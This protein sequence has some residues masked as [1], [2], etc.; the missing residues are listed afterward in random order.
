M[1]STTT[2]ITTI[3]R[4]ASKVDKHAATARVAHDVKQGMH[5][6]K[7][8]VHHGMH[9]GMHYD[10]HG[11]SSGIGNWLH[12]VDHTFRKILSTLLLLAFLAI[13]GTFLLSRMPSLKTNGNIPA[14]KGKYEKVTTTSSTTGRQAVADE[15]RR[16]D[17][18]LR[19]ADGVPVRV[20][21]AIPVVK[22]SVRSQARDT[23]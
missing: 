17:T 15:L 5:D 9:H 22:R 10:M 16:E 23:H 1:G 19:H 21:D 4:A 11:K 7:Q 8:G 20:G 13:V 3:V 2:I 12:G 14:G 6:M 18:T